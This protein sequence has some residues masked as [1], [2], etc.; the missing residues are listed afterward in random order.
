[1]AAQNPPFLLEPCDVLRQRAVELEPYKSHMLFG[2]LPRSVSP[3]PS[4]SPY[5]GDPSQ[6]DRNS[7]P[8]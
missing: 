4:N 2:Y 5:A 8:N 3:Q 6:E 1:M 7:N